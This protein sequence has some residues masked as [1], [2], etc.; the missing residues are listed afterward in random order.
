MEGDE[1]AS[2]ADGEKERLARMRR[3]R[4]SASGTLLSPLSPSNS[5]T[6]SQASTEQLNRLLQVLT[7]HTTTSVRYAS[8]GPPHDPELT[9]SLPSPQPHRCRRPL[10]GFVRRRLRPKDTPHITASSNPPI[11]PPQLRPFR[12]Y[13]APPLRSAVPV[14]E[15]VHRRFLQHDL[16]RNSSLTLA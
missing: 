5:L 11:L 15:R 8:C 7:W 4:R 6:L 9:S 12:L 3:R 13:L 1:Y 10:P 2:S 14:K 16:H